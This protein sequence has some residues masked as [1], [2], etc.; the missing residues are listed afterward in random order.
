M[1]ETRFDQQMQFQPQMR[2]NPEFMIFNP[3]I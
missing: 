2:I 1:R 3:V